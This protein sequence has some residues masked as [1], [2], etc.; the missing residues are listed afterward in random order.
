MDEEAQGAADVPCKVTSVAPACTLRGVDHRDRRIQDDMPTAAIEP[1]A[2]IGVLH[3]HEVPFVES[4]DTGKDRARKRDEH[5]GHPVDVLRA[6]IHRIV[7]GALSQ[8]R[9]ARETTDRRI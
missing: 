7:R 1:A 5:S 6:A 2:Y 3:V 8:K 4:P 9:T